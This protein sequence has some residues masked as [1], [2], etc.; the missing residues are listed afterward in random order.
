ML[1]NNG[2]IHNV[3]NGYSGILRREDDT[4]NLAAFFIYLTFASI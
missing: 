1:H 3:V 4:I 2:I